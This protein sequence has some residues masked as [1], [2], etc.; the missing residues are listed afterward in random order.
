MS[1]ITNWD[2]YDSNEPLSHAQIFE[3]ADK[4]EE[5]LNYLGDRGLDHD[6]FRS[7]AVNHT[8]RLLQSAEYLGA[9]HPECLSLTAAWSKFRSGDAISNKELAGMINSVKAALPYIESRGGRFLM[10]R[11][12]ALTSLG[13]LQ[14]F[15]ASR[16]SKLTP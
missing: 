7:Y 11:K 3:M 10:V 4:F 12:E 8:A 15:Q 5:A 14:Q 9:C 6:V 13:T 1:N 2:L 16:T